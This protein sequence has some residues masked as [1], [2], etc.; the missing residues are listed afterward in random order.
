A[1]MIERVSAEAESAFAAVR[2]RAVL[3]IDAASRQAAATHDTAREQI[4][5]MARESATEVAGFLGALAAAL[6]RLPQEGA[7]IIATLG[8]L[9][10]HLGE[11]NRAWAAVAGVTDGASQSLARAGAAL[12][13]LEHGT[14]AAEQSVLRWSEGLTKAGAGVHALTEMTELAVQL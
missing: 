7:G 2:H 10:A 3:E 5:R 9:R 14:R 12:S 4:A 8:D 11:A 1:T 6:E 13:S